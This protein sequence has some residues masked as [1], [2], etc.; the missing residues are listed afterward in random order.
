MMKLTGAMRYRTEEKRSLF[1]P[2]KVFLVLQV[3]EEYPDGP[4][5]SFGSNTYLAGER[6][7]DATVEDL[8]MLLR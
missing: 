5:D 8:T 7:R 4:A 2:S 1:G 6:W 3:H